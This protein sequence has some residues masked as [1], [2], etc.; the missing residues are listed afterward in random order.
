MT[1][2]A[3]ATVTPHGVFLKVQDSP[4]PQSD[5]NEVLQPPREHSE[6]GPERVVGTWFTEASVFAAG[7]GERQ[8]GGEEISLL[9][10]SSPD[11]SVTGDS[12]V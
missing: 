6:G 3:C 12:R 1:I 4:L 11:S 5:R 2:T 9:V 8:A 7:D 10:P